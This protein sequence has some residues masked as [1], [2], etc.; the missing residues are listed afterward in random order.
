MPDGAQLKPGTYRME[1]LNDA[2]APQVAFY[3]NGKLVCKCPVKVENAQDKVKYTKM[4]YD[5]SPDG[6][7]KLNTIE[8]AGWEQMLVFSGPG[9][10]G[11][12]M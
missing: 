6:T 7:R 3:Q 10:S 2:S 11:G 8:V 5:V 4:L 9:A 12:G 1:L